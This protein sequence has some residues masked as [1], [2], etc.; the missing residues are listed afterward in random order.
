M[1]TAAPIEMFP[2]IH[3]CGE[4][5][6]ICG[7]ADLPAGEGRAVNVGDRRFAIFRSA[8]GWFALDDACPHDGGP[9][10]DGIVADNSVICPLHERRYSLADGSPIGHDGEPTNAHAVSVRGERI[11]LHIDSVLPATA[12]TA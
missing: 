5:I 4:T 6:A 8:T 1:S 7:P 11:I 2:E 3:A 10:S 12:S 9:L